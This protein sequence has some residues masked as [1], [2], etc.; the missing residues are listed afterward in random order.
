MHKKY[1]LA[2]DNLGAKSIILLQTY[3]KQLQYVG[4]EG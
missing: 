4:R 1:L 2:I 3:A